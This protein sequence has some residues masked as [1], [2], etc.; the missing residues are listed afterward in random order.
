MSDAANTAAIEAVAA[1]I[2]RL[3]DAVSAFGG[4]SVTAQAGS[5]SPVAK[6]AKKARQESL[7]KVSA[8]LSTFTGI[9]TDSEVTRQ[10]ATALVMK[11]V[12]DNG[13]QDVDDKRNI[14]PDEALAALIG[15]NAVIKVLN[16]KSSLKDHFS[17]A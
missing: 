15:S 11:Y 5:S 3:A 10:E 8:E 14:V 13:L 4:L 9:S 16:L 6:P 2:N 1:A 7:V 17:A 12:K